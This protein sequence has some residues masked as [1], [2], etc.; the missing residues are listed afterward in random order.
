M[1]RHKVS[2]KL[3]TGLSAPTAWLGALGL[4]CLSLAC[5]RTSEERLMAITRLLDEARSFQAETYAP[6]AFARAESLLAEARGELASHRERS[7]FRGGRG[8]IRQL[9]EESEAAASLARA[10]AAAAVV[11]ARRDAGLSVRDAR[12]ALDQ[13]SEAYWRSP[14]GKDTRDD[15]LRMRADLDVLLTEL[16]EAEQALERGD[17]L[18]ADQ[19]ANAVENR[20]KS[21]TLTIRRASTYRVDEVSELSSE[22]PSQPPDRAAGGRPAREPSSPPGEVSWLTSRADLPRRRA[23]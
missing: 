13:A 10:E 9:L 21:V 2:A 8:R 1:N 14:R 4:S 23:G 22:A 3:P 12:A 11:R 19:L 5:A 7:W 15:L 20:A 18:A 6:R 17:F 16:T